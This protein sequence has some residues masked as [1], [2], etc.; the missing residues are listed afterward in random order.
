M[1]CSNSTVPPKLQ[2]CPASLS[3]VHRRDNGRRL[4]LRFTALSKVVTR[5]TNA[6]RHF[7]PVMPVSGGDG[8]TVRAFLSAIFD[9]GLI[10][11]PTSAVVKQK[12]RETCTKNCGITLEFLLLSIPFFNQRQQLIRKFRQILVAAALVVRNDLQHPVTHALQALIR[13]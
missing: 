12:I 7:Q 13:R 11:P 6:V 3:L 1:K 9:V 8:K 5:T 10:V 2:K 4:P